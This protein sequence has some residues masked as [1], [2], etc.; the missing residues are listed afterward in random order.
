[1]ENYLNGITPILVFLTSQ[2]RIMIGAA[3]LC[4]ERLLN[5]RVRTT[6]GPAWL[7]ESSGERF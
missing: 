6:R 2:Y 7:T 3:E 5:D 4:M 1:M